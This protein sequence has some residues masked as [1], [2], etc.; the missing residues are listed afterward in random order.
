MSQSLTRR[1]ANREATLADIRA[2]ARALLVAEG[3]PG[4]TLRAI[5][6]SIGMTA[7]ALY[8]YFPSR[9]DL[10]RDLI[11]GSFGEMSDTMEAAA[12]AY[13]TDDLAGRLFAAANAFRGWA[14]GHRAEFEL[15]FATPHAKE[16]GLPEDHPLVL[17]GERFGGV[18]LGIFVELWLR[19]PYPVRPDAAV[20][21]RLAEQLACWPAAQQ[22]PLPLGAVEVFLA[23]WVQLY[24]LVSMEVFGHLGF[25]LHDVSPMFDS[26]LTDLAVRLGL[27]YRPE[28]GSAA[29]A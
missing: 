27:K 13:P 11:T 15:V 16:E 2:G 12:R 28:F 6:R 4:V 8:R 18:F 3:H 26:M 7:P 1:E 24:G 23:C 21:P 22:T 5:A 20:D 10:L 9:E 14:L 19:Q 17:A 29:P 25:A